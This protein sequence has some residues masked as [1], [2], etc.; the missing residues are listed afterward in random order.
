MNLDLASHLL[1]PQ[2]IRIPALQLLDDCLEFDRD[3]LDEALLVGRGQHE[4]PGQ[5]LVGDRLDK[6]PRSPG[7]R[8]HQ[9]NPA[10]AGLILVGEEFGEAEPPRQVRVR[11]KDLRRRLIADPVQQVG[12]IV[13]EQRMRPVAVDAG[14]ERP[15]LAVALLKDPQFGYE[16]GHDGNDPRLCDLAVTVSP[17]LGL[18]VLD[19]VH[20]GFHLDQGAGAPVAEFGGRMVGSP[21]G[22]RRIVDQDIDA[23][24]VEGIHDG[25]SVRCLPPDD[26]PAPVGQ[27]APGDFA[28]NE[29]PLRQLFDHRINR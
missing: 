18:D 12:N 3:E 21:G 22:A 20:R 19:D 13:H 15:Q 2:R 14:P 29:T 17:A 28:G 10:V 24:F 8:H 6:A 11:A 26:A 4:G 1:R 16:P 27:C 23:A 5:G 9:V 7:I 25:P